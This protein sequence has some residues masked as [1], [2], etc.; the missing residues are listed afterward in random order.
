MLAG[1][2]LVDAL[3]DLTDEIVQLKRMPG[4]GLIRQAK[5]TWMGRRVLV[6]IWE[7]LH[8]R[9]QGSLNWTLS[10]PSTCFVPLIDVLS[11]SHP[12]LIDHAT[13]RSC[14]LVPTF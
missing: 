3:Q 8:V 2:E 11:R 14:F 4:S 10:P 9:V 12:E 13:A 5:I 6:G 7:T 1:T